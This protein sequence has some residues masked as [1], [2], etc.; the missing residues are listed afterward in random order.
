LKPAVKI[1]EPCHEGG[2]SRNRSRRPGPVVRR[3]GR[4]DQGGHENR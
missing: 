3:A 1:P 4:S 2:D